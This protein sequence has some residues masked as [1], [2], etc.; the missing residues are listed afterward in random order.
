MRLFSISALALA[1][2]TQLGMAQSAQIGATPP[3]PAS[4]VIQ[5]QSSGPELL[6]LFIA[7]QSANL[8]NV[9]GLYSPVIENPGPQKDIQARL[10]KSVE[11]SPVDTVYEHLNVHLQTMKRRVDGT[12]LHR[13]W[14]GAISRDVEIY[15]DTDG[16]M[17]ALRGWV[18]NNELSML[19]LRGDR[20]LR[21]VSMSR[22]VLRA[23]SDGISGGDASAPK[24][25]NDNYIA[26]APDG[27]LLL[28]FDS[29]HRCSGERRMG[30]V[31]RMSPDLQSLNWISPIRVSGGRHFAFN[32]N[33]LFVVDGGSCEKDYLYELDMVTGAVKTR[34]VLPS[35]QDAG[36]FTALD[37][38]NLYLILYNRFMHFKLP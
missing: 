34:E 31:V 33:S 27:G 21:N 15:E 3:L 38:N 5:V 26:Q 6:S 17:V 19:V 25:P 36:D 1:L 14:G 20:G 8:N 11:R 37:G 28:S 10:I 16:T 23:G 7:G 29:S 24:V 22:I 9:T 13:A 12:A 18:S 32:N 35:A 30:V 4:D 2:S